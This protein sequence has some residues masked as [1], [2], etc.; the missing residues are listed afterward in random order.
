MKTLIVMTKNFFDCSLPDE[1]NYAFNRQTVN[2]QQVISSKGECSFL[3]RKGVL[4]KWNFKVH[5]YFLFSQL[6]INSITKQSLS[7]SVCFQVSPLTLQR[8][9]SFVEPFASK[10]KCRK[11]SKKIYR[12]KTFFFY[13]LIT[14][15]FFFILLDIH[16]WYLMLIKL[17]KILRF[18]YILWYQFL[19]IEWKW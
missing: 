6:L 13:T 4:I 11:S 17:K 15:Y 10:C 1:S 16:C 9:C 14:C 3:W 2:W 5:R 18:I 8:C 12:D 19:W 7:A